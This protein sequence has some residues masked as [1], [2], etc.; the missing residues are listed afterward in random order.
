MPASLRISFASLLLAVSCAGVVIAAC[1]EADLNRD[2]TVDLLDVQLLAEQWLEPPEQPADLDSDD[3][4]NMDDFAILAGLWYDAGIPLAINEFMASNSKGIT[5]PQGEYD[6]WIE[7]HNYGSYDIDTAGMYLTDNLGAPTKWRIPAGRPEET[8]IGSGGYLLIWADNDV[9][10][11]GLHAAFELDAGGEEIGLFD[12]DGLTLIDSVEFGEQTGNISSGRYPDATENWQPMVISTPSWGNISIYQ[13]VVDEVQLSHERGF[14][15]APFAVTLATETPDAVIYYTLDGS[16]PFVTTG[17]GRFPRGMV[18]TAAI[19]VEKT[20]V[21]RAMAI[22]MGWMP[23]PAETHTYIFVDDVVVQSPNG[24]VPGPGW[25]TGS[26]NGQVIDYGMDPDVVN[27]SRYAPLMHDA[28]LAVPTISLVTDLANLFDSTKGIY[29]NA[30]QQGRAWERPTSAE[31]IYPDGAEGFQIDAGLRIRGGFSRSNGNPKHAF[32]L[33]FRPEYGTPKLRYPLFGEEGVEEFENVDLRTSQNYS[34]SY[35]GDSRNTMLRDIFS[36]DTQREMDRPYTRSRYYHLYVNGHYWGLFQTQERSEASFGESYFGG[37]KEDYDV[38]KVEPYYVTVTDG[39]LDAYRHLWE[40][41]TAGFD[42]DQRYYRVQGLNPDGTPNPE[43][44]KLLDVENLIDYMVCTFYVGD[45]DG[46]ISNFLSNNRPNNFYGIYNRVAPD[47]FKFF[48]HDA[49]HSLFH[50]NWGIDR[51]GPFTSPDLARFTYCTPQWIH[52][53]LVA[54]PEYRMKFA[55]RAHKHLL[56]GGVLTRDSASERLNTRAQQIETAMIAESARWGD[57]KRSSP[58]TRDNHWRPAADWIL[59][60]FVPGRTNTVLDQLRSKGWYPSVEA[61]AFNYQGGPAPFGFT[62]TMAASGETIYYTLDGSDPRLPKKPQGGGG[63]QITLVAENAAKRVL[64]PT[65]PVSDNWKGGE[66]FDDSAW[67]YTV[68]GPGGVGYERSSGY[69]HLISLNVEDQMFEK[70]TGCYV[71]IQFYISG[72]PNELTFMTLGVRYDDAFV[73][74]LNG[75]KIEGALFSGEPEWNSRAD[76]NHE[77]TGLESFYVSDHI[78][79]L[80]QG[81]NIL[82]L[83]GLNVSETSSDFIISAELVAGASDPGSGGGVSPTAIKYTG[84]VTLTKTVRVKARTLAGA[85][86]SALNEA[87]FVVGPVV[88][89]LR[90]TEMMYHPFDTGD[91]NDPNDPNEEFV[92]LTNIGNE[93]INL[94]LVRFANGIDFT[95]ADVNLVPGQHVVVV[96]EP[97]TF[98]AKYGPATEVLGRYDGRLDNGGERIR[99][100]DAIGR[101]ILDFKYKDGWRRITDGDGYSLTI[102]N[103]ANP[104]PGS[105]AMKDSWRA[106][107]YEGGSPGQDDSGIIPNPGSVVVNEILAHSHGGAPDWVEL[108]NTTEADIDIGGWYLSDSEADLKKYR[109]P[110]GTKIKSDRYKVF[111]EDEHFGEFSSDVGSITPFAFS[112]NGDQL[113]LTAAKAGVLLGYREVE[114]FGASETNVSFGRYHKS[115]TDTYNFVPMADQ[116]PGFENDDPKVGPVVITEI[117]YHPDW[118]EGG[119]YPNNR[120]EYIELKNITTSSVTLMV[121]DIDMALEL[122]W[123]F[124]DGINFTFP[125]DPFV[126]IPPHSYILVV[127]DPNAFAWRYPDVDPQIVFGPYEGWLDNGGERLEIAKPGDIDKFGRRYY[128]R[129]DRVVYS[130]GAHPGDEPGDVDL[131]PTGPDGGGTSL[132]KIEEGDYGNDP[133]NWAADVPSPGQ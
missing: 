103:P 112:E 21:L 20:T 54:H 63:T 96:R 57:A 9:E 131:W 7:I 60:T 125:N 108:Y 89:N 100:Q 87:V 31:L 99:L 83:H 18:Y 84:P 79:D 126:T 80:H 116:T 110:A 65:G 109:I 92:E 46:P 91:P 40:A 32:R 11:I 75:R 121:H 25:P 48:R 78:S 117:M 2:C 30:R 19:A 44:E 82:A 14:Y 45:F 98:A 71:R 22:K 61:P 10:D 119:S 64:V 56:N 67:T 17:G 16:E 114:D 29:V 74:Y 115:S 127:K 93:T 37:D 102:I 129:V 94:N 72:D 35:Q 38:V 42:D 69:G 111:Y 105:W 4:V 101:T 62:L 1:P 73:A 28:L 6:D 107:A 41:A 58:F 133:N 70:Q 88:E 53:Q 85:A 104:D 123:K 39:N 23:S 55:D 81:W 86:W 15:D 106:S 59:D 47:G 33:M 3:E 24:Q 8:T 120:Y 36:R 118:P 113:Y 76:G 122:P 43:Y 34:W 5:D 124:T 130:D 90:I 51:T 66:P 50:H 49:E 52:Q 95:F 68:G 27:N 97:N 13:G 26:V 128:I 132:N 12:V 77:S